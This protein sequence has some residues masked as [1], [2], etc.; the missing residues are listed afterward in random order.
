MGAVDV[1]RQSPNVFRMKL[2]GAKVNAV[3]S[4]AQTL[5]DAMNEALRDWVT[6]VRDTYYLIGTA[7]GPHPYP[8]MV[9]NFQSVIGN[10]VREQMQ[11]GGG[12]AAR[13]AGG[14]HRRRLQRDRPVPSVPRRGERQD[15]RRGGRRARARRRERPLRLDDRRQAGRAARQPHLSAAERR[16]PDPG[17][18]FDLG[19]ASTIRASGRSIPGSRT[20][21]A[22]PTSPSPTRRRS[23]PSSCAPGSRAS[24]RRWSRRTRWPT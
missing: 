5:K 6:N 12:P 14:L 17:G 20:R 3:T 7:A 18:P 13:H 10:E 21:A 19:R 2:L 9:R 4:G 1:A 8:E 11:A 16:R 15:L 24:S 23:R 22:S